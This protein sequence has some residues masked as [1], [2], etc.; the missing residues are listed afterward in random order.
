LPFT[1]SMEDEEI[2][3]EWECGNRT[4]DLLCSRRVFPPLRHIGRQNNGI[5]YAFIGILRCLDF[6]EL[7][8]FVEYRV[9]C[10]P[11]V[12]SLNSVMRS[13]IWRAGMTFF[14]QSIRTQVFDSIFRH[15]SI[16]NAKCFVELQYYDSYCYINRGKF[17]SN[18]RY[19]RSLMFAFSKCWLI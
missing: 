4:C 12:L 5:S 3:N 17:S 6:I 11:L 19:S 15:D 2:G 18:K 8:T 1:I 9:K 16:N 7:W 10:H 13:T 14:T